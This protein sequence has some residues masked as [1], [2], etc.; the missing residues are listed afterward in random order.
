MDWT[1]NHLRLE[2]PR[3]EYLWRGEEEGV[4]RRRRRRRRRRVEWVSGMGNHPVKTG[5]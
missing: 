4:R 1:L 5:E 2:S 3:K